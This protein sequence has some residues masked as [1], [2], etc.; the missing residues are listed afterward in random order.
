MVPRVRPGSSAPTTAVCRKGE[1]EV[2]KG[3]R[4]QVFVLLK[5]VTWGEVQMIDVFR[6]WIRAVLGVT[7]VPTRARESAKAGPDLDPAF[8]RSRKWRL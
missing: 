5:P 1:S 7:R 2:G 6:V 8:A 3:Y 4:Y